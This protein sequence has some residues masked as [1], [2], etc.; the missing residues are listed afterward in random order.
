[1]LSI[2]KKWL[3]T[4][5]PALIKQRSVPYRLHVVFPTNQMWYRYAIVCCSLVT[6]AAVKFWLVMLTNS[7]FSTI[8]ESGVHK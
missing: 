8:L 1:M 7:K 3:S 4:I 2:F 5:N 6:D